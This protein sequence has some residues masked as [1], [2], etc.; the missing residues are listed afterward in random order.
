M[1]KRFF[2]FLTLALL[3]NIIG[4]YAENAEYIIGIRRNKNDEKYIHASPE[5]QKQIDELVN[6]KMNDIY[7]IIE[8]K[9]DTYVLD[10]GEMDNNLNEL[11][12]VNQLRKRSNKITKFY[13]INTS[14]LKKINE[15]KKRSL[16][17]INSNT[18]STI[19]YI[20]FESN[21]INHVCPVLNYYAVNA[22]LSDEVAKIVCNLDNVIHCEKSVPLDPPTPIKI[23]NLNE[24]EI[25][26]INENK[27]DMNE[28]EYET[29]SSPI[30]YDIEKIKNETK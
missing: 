1:N 27:N 12:E 13:F 15:Y 2:I 6:D 22:Y 16:D 25:E 14:S 5:V 23:K 9:K 7:E 4:I 3:S 21:I 30:Y 19:E 10:N 29:D 11:E 28:T 8:D 17:I 18:N 20:P 26:I 24:T